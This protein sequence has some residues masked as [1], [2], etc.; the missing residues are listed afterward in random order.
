MRWLWAIA[1]TA[2][3]AAT[4]TTPKTKIFVDPINIFVFAHPLFLIL[5]CAKERTSERVK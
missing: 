4:T 5:I 1:A 3:A 2:S